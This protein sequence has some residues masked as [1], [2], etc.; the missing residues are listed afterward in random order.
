MRK[1]FLLL[2]TAA[3][4][5]G[6]L[7]S[8]GGGKKGTDTGSGSGSG[9]DTSGGGDA[10]VPVEEGKV[11]FYFELGEGSQAIPDYCAPY[12][13]GK[14]ADINAEAWP[15]AADKA[16][17]MKLVSGSTT[18][19]YGTIALDVEALAALPESD[20]P[21]DYQLTLGYTPDSGN[22]STGVNWG[23]KSDVC[24]AGGDFDNPHFEIV[25]GKANLGTHKWE[26]VPG[27]VLLAENVTFE[28]KLA[29]PAPS[30]VKLFAPGAYLNNWKCDPKEDA[31]TPS[32]D[33]KT[34][35]FTIPEIAANTYE[36]KIIVE[37]ADCAAFSWK[38]D[39]LHGAKQADDPTKFTNYS[40]MIL[41]T[42]S[43]KTIV[44]NDDF[45][46]MT[47][48]AVKET[49]GLDVN[50]NYEIILD[51]KDFPDPATLTDV[52]VS[53]DITLDEAYTGT[54]V[55]HIK[56]SFDGWAAEHDL[57]ISEDKL[58]FTYD[59]G[60]LKEN[61]EF[62]LYVDASWNLC[63]KDP[64][65]SNYS[66]TL[67]KTDCIVKISLTNAAMSQAVPETA[68][69]IGTTLTVVPANA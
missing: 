65:G 12:L 66:V 40:L 31:M 69:N 29:E 42:D 25:D 52:N 57:V 64:S 18:L 49:Y 51:Y 26:K 41:S 3:L 16:V 28:V 58:H 30:Y 46:G 62:G 11:T 50:E 54:N 2:V 21:Y 48:A 4:G 14:F 8:C 33:R 27:P 22:P 38:L 7:I 24:S 19:Y 1:S 45:D 59:F 56:G 67:A 6:T 60:K 53:L 37:Y 10:S 61:F 20:K 17:E 34:W 13:T 5:L 9:T 63:A 39:A 23:F 47:V 44:T 32:E 55:W 43:N 68:T 15:T 36:L 35:S